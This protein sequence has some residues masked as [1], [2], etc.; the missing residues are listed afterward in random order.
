MKRRYLTSW[1]FLLIL[2]AVVLFLTGRNHPSV[3]RPETPAPTWD[4]YFSPHGGATSA[5]IKI[6][7]QA[8]KSI[9]VQAYSFTSAPIASAL[10]RAHRRGVEVQVIVDK[11]Q[12]TDRNLSIRFLT[13]PGVVTF[14]DA[15]HAIAHNK[16]MIIDD[17]IV[18]TGSFNFT[19]AAEERNAE[20]LL[21]IRSK[22]LAARFLANWS[23]H[24]RHSTP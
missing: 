21:I 13:Y 18:I 7:D 14:V 11:S 17:E 15:V 1:H 9:L 10:V 20:N 4:V 8:K 5:I 22:E 6:L 12:R 2:T 3:S 23:I 16:M 24:R 19:K